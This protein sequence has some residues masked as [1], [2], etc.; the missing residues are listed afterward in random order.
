MRKLLYS[1]YGG[2]L[3][4]SALCLVAIAILVG[5]QLGGR[6]LD[7]AL[8]LLGLPV[9]GFVVLSL[10]E[11]AGYLLAAA[12]FLALAGTLKSGAHIRVTLVLAGLSENARRYVELWAFGASAAFSGYMTWNIGSFAWVSL[13][14]NEVSSG[15]IPVPLV[16]PQAAMA[17]GV[18]I[19]TV[20][21]ID[22]FLIVLSGSRPTF[23]ATEDA[24]TLG[25]EG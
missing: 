4:L 23:R 24:I 6:L 19:L 9:Y 5:L 22:E 21:L 3:I 7:A 16:Y 25:K 13:R 20:A 1:L 10:A 8:K 14:F 18:F 11:I 15:L 17:V 12:S 2:A